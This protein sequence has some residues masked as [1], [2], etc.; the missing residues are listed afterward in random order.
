MPTELVKRLL[1]LQVYPPDQQ[2][3]AV[4]MVIEQAETVCREW[5]GQ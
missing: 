2:E 3:A 5:G 4:V 1:Q